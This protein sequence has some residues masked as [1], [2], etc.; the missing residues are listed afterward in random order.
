MFSI[1]KKK[2]IKKIMNSKCYALL[3]FYKLLLVINMA[4]FRSQKQ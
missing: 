2:L 4:Q 3:A 1:L